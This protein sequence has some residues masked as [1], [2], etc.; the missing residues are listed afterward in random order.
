[1]TDSRFFRGKGIAF[2]RIFSVPISMEHIKIIQGIDE[3]ISIDNMTKGMEV[4]TEI[5]RRLCIE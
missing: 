4:F 3:Q 5:V 1:M 2:Y